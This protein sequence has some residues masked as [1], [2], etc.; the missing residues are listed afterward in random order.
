MKLRFTEAVSVT[1][2]MPYPSESIVASLLHACGHRLHVLPT[3][4]A[5]E[6]PNFRLPNE[7]ELQPQPGK[8]FASQG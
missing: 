7:M 5:D 4:E 6:V 2:L 3:L 1:N 8:C